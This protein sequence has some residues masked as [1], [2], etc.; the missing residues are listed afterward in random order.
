MVIPSTYQALLLPAS[1]SLAH[2]CRA[3][4]TCIFNGHYTLRFAGGEAKVVWGCWRSFACRPCVY[5]V[6]LLNRAAFLVGVC[7]CY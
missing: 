3:S 1:S 6:S 7:C 2:P 5:E 4:E